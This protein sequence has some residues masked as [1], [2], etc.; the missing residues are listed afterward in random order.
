MTTA[1]IDRLKAERRLI[2]IARRQLQVD[3]AT[4]QAKVARITAGRARSTLEC[5]L[6]ELLQIKGEYQRAGFQ[7][8]PHRGAGRTPRPRA[9]ASEGR[10]ALHGTGPMLQKIGALL[11]DLKLGWG[12]AAGIHRQQKGLPKGTACPLELANAQELRAVI[13]ALAR[14]QKR[15]APPGPALIHPHPEP[16]L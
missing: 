6:G 8:Q 16:C 1:E 12:Y 5:T 7:A 4:H 10:S 2:G 3:D 14:H 9:T 11:A 13:A 15:Q